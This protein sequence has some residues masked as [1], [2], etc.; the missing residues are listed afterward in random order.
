MPEVQRRRD[1]E[2]IT[3]TT[4]QT[5]RSSRN[6]SRELSN[7]IALTQ[8]LRSSSYTRIHMF[9][10]LEEWDKNRD[11]L[12]QGISRVVEGQCDPAEQNMEPPL[13]TSAQRLAPPQL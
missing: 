13:L 9:K 4:T 12:A 3:N 11:L 2:I 1:E 6:T 5:K 8:K 7:S 10:M